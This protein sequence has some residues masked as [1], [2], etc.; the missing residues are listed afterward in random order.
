MDKETREK[1]KEFKKQKRY[2]DI[3]IN[4][5]TKAYIKNTPTKYR[6]KELKKLKKEGRYLDIYNK[7]GEKE[8]NKVLVKARTQEIKE[9]KGSFQAFTWEATQNIKIFLKKLGIN[10]AIGASTLMLTMPV[11]VQSTIN[12]NAIKY[13]KEIENY[14]ENIS[15][16]AEEVKSLKLNHLQTIMKVMDDMWKN[17]AGYA[18]P[19]KDIS[20]FLELDLA[21]E[22]GYGVC[23]NMASDVAKKLNKIDER[24]NARTINVKM[25]HGDYQI[26]NIERKVIETNETVEQENEQQGSNI[27]ENLAGNHMV[28]LVD[29]P[30]RD[31]TLVADPTNPGLGIYENGEIKMFNT[32]EKWEGKEIST[33]LLNG[34]EGLEMGGT[35]VN[36]F[37]LKSKYSEAKKEFGLEKQNEALNYVRSLEKQNSEKSKEEKFRESLAVASNQSE[38]IRR[39]EQ[40][41]DG[42]INAQEKETV[43]ER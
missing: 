8:Y 12:K 23:R 3:F 42:Q 38:N 14:D 41:Q 34:Y 27:L 21:T 17:I 6:Q 36:S 15:K 39:D 37:H 10:V 25:E 32:D 26:A 31:I 28:T 35:Y 5:G 13:E 43:N 11:V 2:D 33:M 24:Y 16:Y 7:Y 29:I 4:Y 9:A 18:N 40:N 19:E 20:G 30:D 22:D 1:I